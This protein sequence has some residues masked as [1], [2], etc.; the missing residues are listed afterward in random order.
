MTDSPEGKKADSVVNLL[1][2]AK[3]APKQATV[4]GE[5]A[6]LNVDRNGVPIVAED[7]V[8]FPE[9]LMELIMNETDKES[10]W[11]QPD[12]NAFCINSKKFTKTILANNF[13]GS[14]FESFTRKLARW[15]VVFCGVRSGQ[16]MVLSLYLI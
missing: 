7:G 13:Q 4:A 11:W 10:L 3:K 2:D 14:K 6:K 12:G 5:L 8:T 9:R 1:F 16:I 15:Y